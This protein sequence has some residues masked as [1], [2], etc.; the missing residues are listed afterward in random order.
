MPED[1]HSS[2]RRHPAW[3]R[4]L[5][6]RHEL[7]VGRMPFQFPWPYGSIFGRCAPSGIEKRHKVP[8][9]EL[10]IFIADWSRTMAS[11]TIDYILMIEGYWRY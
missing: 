8:D 6:A 2:D 3:R 10:I 4:L 7:Q 9:D 5:L 11:E 1:E